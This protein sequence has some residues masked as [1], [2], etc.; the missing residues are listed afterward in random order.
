MDI[1]FTIPK[2]NRIQTQTFEEFEIGLYK[3]MH[4]AK[5]SFF[6]VGYWL[7]HANDKYNFLQDNG[8]NNITEYAY[9]KF[10][11]SKSTTY[12]LIKVYRTFRDESGYALATEYIRFSQSQ[13]VALSK[14]KYKENN[15]L[16]KVKPT[17]TISDIEKAVKIYNSGSFST[18]PR[19]YSDIKEYIENHET[20]ATKKPSI[21]SRRLEKEKAEEIISSI[22]TVKRTYAILLKS[23]QDAKVWTSEIRSIFFQIESAFTKLERAINNSTT[24]E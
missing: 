18:T 12:D 20:S 1:A 10:G 5:L 3:A 24:E 11:L 4:R 22:V 19:G 21:F 23:I 2:N 8:Y 14:M 6:E 13:L 15:F 9:E 16:S 7:Y 17:D